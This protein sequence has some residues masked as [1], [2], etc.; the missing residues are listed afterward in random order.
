MVLPLVA[1]TALAAGTSTARADAETLEEIIVTAEKQEESLQKTAAA[2]TAIQGD[3]LVAA[4]VTDLRAAQKLVPSVRFQAEGANTE[5]YIRGV[6]STLDLPNIEP[7]TTVNFNGI[8]IPREA[9]SVPLFDV[10]QIEV[11]PGTQGTLYGRSVLGGAVNIAFNRP[12][13]DLETDLLLEAGNYSLFHATVTQNLPVTDTFALRGSIDYTNHDGYLETGADSKDDYAIRLSGLYEPNDDLSIL[14]W[15]QA[16]EKDGKSANLVRKGYN[17]GTFDGDP[18]AFESSDPWNDVITPDAPDA[19]SQVYEEWIVGAQVDWRFNG[20][21]LTY[22][23]SYLYLD[24]AGNYWLENLPAFLSAHYNQV[25]QEL[26]LGRT[27]DRWD[28]LVGLMR[29]A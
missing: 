21:T 2:V 27:R 23:P 4:G 22:I 8:Y 19:G 15:T 29:I 25:T 6:G 12:T 24:W 13:Q 14:V 11:L 26:R 9:T 10:D 17:G 3:A 28:W 20:M 5:V 7:P 16:A 18:H 1:L